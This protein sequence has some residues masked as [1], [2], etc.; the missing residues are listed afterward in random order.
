MPNDTQNGQETQAEET[1]QAVMP[2]TDQ[3]AEEKSAEAS[4]PLQ[5]E[6]SLPDG[7][8]ERTKA[9]F[10]K[11]K[12]HNRLLAEKLAVLEGGYRPQPTSVLDEFN[13]VMANPGNVQPGQVEELN[14]INTDEDGYVD[15]AVVNKAIAESNRLAKE[16]AERAKIAEERVAR[17]EQN[18]QVQK[19]HASFP[20]LDPYSE[21]FDPKFYDLVKNELTGQMMRGQTDL[22]NAAKKVSE[23]YNPVAIRQAQAQQQAE[24]KKQSVEKLQEVSVAPTSARGQSPVV[25][26]SVEDGL[27]KGDSVAIGTLL[28]ASGY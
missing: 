11:L 25:E 20:H 14:Q 5:V 28:Q 24:V 10:E 2:T 26:P 27:R 9:E 15:M 1:Q 19:V 4:Q 13:P 22:M 6:P 16:A 8:S 18:E 21:N 7:A 3:P 12:E 23:W 17:F